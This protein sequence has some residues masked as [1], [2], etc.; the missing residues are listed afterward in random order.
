MEIGAGSGLNF[1]HYHGNQV[2]TL[3]AVEPDENLRKMAAEG[4]PDG[5]NI[6]I[7]DGRGEDIPLDD[8]SVDSVVITFT[9]CSVPSPDEILKEAHRVLKPGGKL[10]VAEHGL[11]P[12][13]SVA[14]WQHRLTPLWKRLAGGCHLNR[15]FS[16]HLEGA[17]FH[18]E[19]KDSQYLKDLPKFAAYVTSICATKKAR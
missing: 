15:D 14:V 10:Y 4:V 18:V 19:K 11:A 1:R 3:C 16:N 13:E 17:G 6:D 12:D 8:A 5:L 2:D 9:L 7:V